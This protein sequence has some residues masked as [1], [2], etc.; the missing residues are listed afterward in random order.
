[1]SDIVLLS[2]RNAGFLGT[3]RVIE[4]SL[5]IRRTEAIVGLLATFS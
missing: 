5:S 1:M 3:E 2:I 4:S